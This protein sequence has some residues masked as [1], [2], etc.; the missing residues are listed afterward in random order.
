[1]RIGLNWHILNGFDR[2]LV[3]HNGGTGGYRTF[4]G[5][6]PPRQRAV[7][8]LSNQAT[9]PDDIGFHLLDARAP[10]APAPKVRTAIAVDPAVLESYVGVYQ[11]APA[12]ALT[13]TREG[14]AL[15]AQATGQPKFELFAESLTEFFLNVVDAQVTFEKDAAG[16]VTGLVLHQGGMNLPGSKTK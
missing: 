8:V 2:S 14:A 11:L 10:L 1:M 16:K 9:A 15:F 3:W 12:F 6:D 7:I 4:I 5:M 13:V